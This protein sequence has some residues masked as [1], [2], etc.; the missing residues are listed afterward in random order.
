MGPMPK[1]HFASAKDTDM[2]YLVRRRIPDPFFHIDT[3]KKKLVFLNALEIDAF[4]EGNSNKKLK[5]VPL[6]LFVKEMRALKIKASPINKLALVIFKKHGLLKKKVSVSKYFP[7]DMAD[8][9]RS[10]GVI[11]IVADD[12][13]P[14]RRT[15]TRSEIKHIRDSVARTCKAFAFIEKVLRQSKI[16]GNK[17]LYK[18]KPLTSEFLKEEVEFLLFKEGLECPEGLIISCGVHAAM[19]HHGGSGPIR[20]HQ[21]IVCDIFPRDRQTGYFADVTRTFVKGRPSKKVTDMYDAVKKAQAES[22]NVV[23]SGVKAADVHNVSAKVI[24]EA[25]FDVGEKGLPAGRQG[26]I[27]GLGHGVGLDVHEHPSLSPASKDVLEAGDVITIE[28]GLYYPK[29]GGVRLED[30]VVVTKE[31]YENLTDLKRDLIIA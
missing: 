17:L 1:V 3:G 6:Q 26:Y 28:P 25:G 21:T 29:W 9:L 15:K 8:F 19:P 2:F 5:A 13:L 18:G 23:K 4:N 31:G 14:E 30:V 7:L 20:P 22:M 27:H 16:S 10:Q 11:L 24:K 12:F